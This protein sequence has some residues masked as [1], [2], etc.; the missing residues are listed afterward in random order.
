MKKFNIIFYIFVILIV[1]LG[2]FLRL[3]IYLF[4]IPFWI[5]EIVL[6]QSFIDEKFLNF[7]HVLVDNQKAPP[8]FCSLVLIVQKIFGYNEYS[9]RLI[10]LLSGILSLFA[11]YFLLNDYIKSKLV[12]LTGL[13]LFAV[14]PVLI[15]YSAEFKPYSSDVLI[16]ILLLF[17]YKYMSL[18]NIQPF[19]SIWAK[20]IVYLIISNII[21]LFSFPSILIIPSM[22]IAKFIEEKKIT[23][24]GVMIFLG[25]F[26]S[27]LYLYLV[28]KDLRVTEILE[29]DWQTGFI[30]PS[31]TSLYAT[32]K[33]FYLFVIQPGGGITALLY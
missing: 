1:V 29:N 21:I 7:F 11:F 19:K 28:Y 8:L 27:S 10:P 12:L 33:D 30:K 5:D 3:K 16:C 23:F 4:K 17:S 20:V 15:Y 6:S 14:N 31:A 22:M 32:F 9:L 26:T 18:K 2:I 24:P 25:S 13:F